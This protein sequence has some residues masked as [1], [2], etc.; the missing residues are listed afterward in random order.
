MPDFS[1]VTA[2][3][4]RFPR[5]VGVSVAAIAFLTY[6]TAL[7]NGFVTWDDPEY[8]AA[9]PMVAAGLTVAGLRYAWTTFDMGNWI[10]VTW[11]SYQL[12]ATLFGNGPFG[13]HFTNVALHATNAW[14]LYTVLR[15][16]TG[17][18]GRSGLVALWF[19]VH[20][21]HVESVAWIAERKDVLS[22]CGLLLTLL[23]YQRYVARPSPSRYAIMALVFAIGLLA[24]SMLVTLPILLLLWDFWPLQRLPEIS[25]VRSRAAA[26]P[27]RTLTHRLVEKLPL[28]ALAVVDG[29]VTIRA[30]RAALM[31]LADLPPIAR[32]AHAVT[33]C[34]WYLEKTL[35]PTNLCPIYP[36]SGIACCRGTQ[37]RHSIAYRTNELPARSQDMLRCPADP[38]DG[39]AGKF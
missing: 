12:D 29:L 39:D 24:K 32:L 17:A 18:V 16:A 15:A 22:G 31:P 21:L 1:T 28:L 3:L 26:S 8:V 33:A 20:P 23:A 14:L 11:M 34:G 38:K 13:F 25:A 4:C 36:R 6:L 9:N 37:R 27:W 10:P 19:A 2:R 30:Q 5:L 35:W 7:G